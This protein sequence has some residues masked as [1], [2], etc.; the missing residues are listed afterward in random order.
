MP[1]TYN[2]TITAALYASG[3]LLKDYDSKTTISSH[4]LPFTSSTAAFSVCGHG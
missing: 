2:L 4:R 3:C 1:V